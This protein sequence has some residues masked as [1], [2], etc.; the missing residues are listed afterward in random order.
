MTITS[1]NP[2]DLD[3]FVADAGRRRR[4]LESRL[5]ELA[6]LTSAVVAGCA[7]FAVQSNVVGSGR[8]VM[9]VLEYDER[10]VEKVAE[11]LRRAD[12][13]PSS[14]IASIGS[15]QVAT[16]L[17]AAGLAT[18]PGPVEVEPGVLLGI[19]PTSGFVDDPI[20]AANGNFVEVET[21]LAFPG[22]SAVLDVVRVYNSLGSNVLG[23][24]GRGWSSPLDLRL[25]Y[26]DGGILRVHLADGAVVPFVADPA[27][28]AGAVGTALRAVGNR[29]LRVERADGGWLLRE[30]PT[31]AWRF[32]ADGRF[33]GGTAGPATLEVER[34]HE[35]VVALRERRSGRRVTF[36][37][38]GGR[39]VAAL[40][41]DGRR[42]TY[43][44]DDDGALV[45]VDRPTGGRTYEVAEGRIAAVADAD[46][47]VLARNVYDEA[48][49]VLEQTNEL[50]RTTRYLYT[51]NGT[52]VIS[53][54]TGGPR[55]AYTHDGRGNVTAVVDGTGRAMRIVYDNAGHAVRVTA[56]DGA[57]R[58]FSY[59]DAGN[60]VRRVDPDGLAAEWVWDAL[61]RL[62]VETHRNGATTTYEYAG[63]G[64][65][66][67]RITDPLGGAITIDVDDVD[68]PVR[69]VDADGVETRLEW[70]DDGQVVAVVDALGNRTTFGYDGAGLLER[71]VDATGAVTELRSD[72]GG[73]VVEALVGGAVSR[74]AYT[75][76]GRPIGGADQEGV[77]WSATY[78]AHGRVAT[79][80]DGLGSTV[81]YEWDVLGD[82]RAVVAPDGERFEQEF[83][84]VGRLIAVRDPDG[85]TSRSEHDAEGRVV[86]VTDPA[87]RTWRREVDR[88]GRTTAVVDPTGARTTYEYHPDGTVARVVRPGRA[89]VATEVDAAGRVTAIVDE[90]GERFELV[91]SAAGRLRERRFPSGRVE[92]WEYDAA[93]RVVAVGPPGDE[94]RLE[95]DGRGRTVA[96]RHRGRERRWRYDDGGDVVA[97]EGDVELR[98]ERDRAGRV[99]ALTD[100]T[101]VRRTY[102]YD[103][104]GL[105]AA[106]SEAPGTTTTFERD[107]RG[108]VAT[109][110]APDGAR[111]TYG[112]DRTGH[113]RTLTDPLGT[114]ERVLDPSGR[115][116]AERW[117]GGALEVATDPLGRLTG[118]GP[119]PSSPAATFR[120]DD[121]G[122]LAEAVRVAGD[123]RTTFSW[124]G[125]GRLAEVT[126]PLGATTSMER[127]ADGAVQGWRVPAGVVRVRRDLAGR[128]VGLDDP[129]AG[130]VDAPP[131]PAARQRDAGGRITGSARGAVH[132]YDGAGRL[133]ESLDETGARWAFEY[134]GAGLLVREASPLGVRRYGRGPLGRLERLEEGDGTVTTFGYDGAGRRTSAT[135]SD[136]T[137]VR[138]SWDELGHLRSVERS[139]ADGAVQ[140]L[141]IDVDAWGRP[142][143]VGG[144]E[145]EWDEA[146]TGRPSRIGSTRYLH[147]AGRARA[148][149]PGADWS[150]ESRDP[151]GSS[152]SGVGRDEPILGFGDELAAWGLVWM[153]ARIYDTTTRE[154]LSPDP[155]PPVADRAGSASVYAYGFQDPVNH[156]DPTGERP[157]SQAEFDQLRERE[158]RGRFGQVWQAIKD[159]PWGTLAMVAI[160]TVGVAM[161][162][163]GFGAAVGASIL[164]GVA[165]SAAAGVATGT[166]DPKMVAAGGALGVLPGG[167]S[168]RTAIAFNAGYSGALEGGLQAVRGDFDA[169]N[170]VLATALGGA[171]GGA[172]H[173]LNVRIQ[174]ARATVE[175]P[176]PATAPPRSGAAEGAT[177]A[178][179]TAG[180]TVYRVYGGD[181]AAGGASW[182]PVDPGSVPNFRDAAG[183]PSGGA[184]GATNTGQF[185]IEGTLNDPSA[186]VLQRNALP[187]DGMKGGIPEY[188]IP[189]W[190]DN[191]S[192]TINRVS[193]VNPEF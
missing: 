37:W 98:I 49:K 90:R 138:W 70:D 127:D 32:D 3:R 74:Y 126:G 176:A 188:I 88:L 133:V 184:S 116:V 30:G 119:D 107:D 26:V 191:G 193:G 83:D 141:D 46:G 158:E 17:R 11:T 7:D 121:A 13:D 136:G 75:A 65:Q 27:D 106:A 163:T 154:F 144:T 81:G 85:R 192:I 79:F 52:T 173:G 101:G 55:N 164:V 16:A 86:A 171:T 38:D 140:R 15:A 170:L 68:Q 185:V 142:F 56:R 51:E 66:P 175:A 63:D 21:D 181:S 48:G 122:R 59:D 120:Y 82:L 9:A 67:T 145:V 125:A 174:G 162:A 178:E 76:A 62:V 105:V 183:L 157:I 8:S 149:T 34:E 123:I 50:G 160:T 5:Q 128:I 61:G 129:D 115:V 148:A 172:A 151:W 103:A 20:C 54:T 72:E 45:A 2:D 114:V 97:V 33:V 99:T 31:K 41:D 47:V 69:V 10:F 23:A 187:L 80:T 177:V 28:P 94:A 91:W 12:R 40:S 39:V 89:V 71:T 92:R 130:A 78:G 60:L 137:T 43:R 108:R 73:R 100:G 95:L 155:R 4:T 124:D 111:T 161:V 53:D 19:P 153:G 25:S 29:P 117:A 118:L 169:G 104:R 96:L 18:P 165:M 36:E 113:L 189:N 102:A 156:L 35:R 180:Q 152:V 109:V 22:T 139:T 58:L 166:F 134:D 84:A 24:F 135:R 14:G 182:S 150:G 93:G 147:L 131:P 190:M 146:L 112:Y 42:V 87:G 110:T 186:V 44:Y 159:D 179:P 1:A 77:S 167:S 64:R 57:V 168:Y 143:R 132:R 6:G